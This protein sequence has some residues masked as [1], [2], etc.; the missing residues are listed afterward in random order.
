MH[1]DKVLFE[2][3]CLTDNN[4]LSV[5]EMQ[6]VLTYIFSRTAMRDDLFLFLAL[7]CRSTKS[8][9]VSSLVCLVDTIDHETPNFLSNPF[10]VTKSAGTS[11]SRSGRISFLQTTSS[12]IPCATCRK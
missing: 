2:K 5:L 4:R 9:R 11:K 7:H 1:L 8:S 3:D 6:G 10:D 12:Y